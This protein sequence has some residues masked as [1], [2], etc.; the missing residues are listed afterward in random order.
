MKDYLFNIENVQNLFNTP[1]FHT[2]VKIVCRLGPLHG[3]PSNFSIPFPQFP[4]D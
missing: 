4:Y 1:I 3:E 2:Y